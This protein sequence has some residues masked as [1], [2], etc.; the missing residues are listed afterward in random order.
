MLTLKRAFKNIWRRRFRT[1]LVGIVLALC[2]AVFVS[3]IASVDASEATTAAMLED[4]E[5]AAGSTIEQTELSMTAI[6]VASSK[7]MFRSN[8]GN[9]MD[10]DIVDE[11]IGM[12]NVA[13][14]VP[15]AQ[16]GFGEAEG[17]GGGHGMMPAY[18]VVGVPLDSDFEQY[19]QLPA[20]I[21][22]GR[23][24]NEG[25]NDAV[26]IGRELTDYFDAGVGD[27]IEI[28]GNYFEV[29]GVYTSGFMEDQVYMSLES[30]QSLLD[31]EGQ[32]SALTVY[33]E[34]ADSVDNV[35]AEL[36]EAYPDYMVMSMSDMQSQFGDRIVNEQ[37]SIIGSIDSNLTSVQSLGLSITVISAL[38]GVLLIFGLM[39]YSVRERTK[40]IGTLKAI[41][42]SNG[43]VM[44]QFM[45]EGMYVGLIGGIIG[46]GLAAAAAS[47]FGSF[48]LNPSE[49]LGESVSVSITTMSIILG[50]V[51]AIVAGSL[52]SLYPAW[53]ASRVS[54]MESLRRE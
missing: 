44:K 19:S 38:I 39:F 33:A 23:S 54:P 2:V 53:R 22:D 12:D 37:Q 11:I 51:V 4:Y 47:G 8:D 43:D 9:G 52:G 24:L 1:A 13:A 5:S 36:E 26:I 42:F 34:D 29:V 17:A 50:L 27:N 15:M 31:M 28:D 45:Y 3:T 48:L 41:G 21:T 6:T 20:N 18:R 14:V 49:T 25:E 35:V 32:L 30:A 10:E 16:G 7:G 46:L 40:E